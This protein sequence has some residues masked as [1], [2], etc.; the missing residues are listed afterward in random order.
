MAAG[1]LPVCDSVWI[2]AQA[3][4]KRSSWALKVVTGMSRHP[5]RRDWFGPGPW[6]WMA[7]KQPFWISTLQML[8]VFWS[9]AKVVQVGPV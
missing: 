4:L 7:L 1:A 2:R 8:D 3:F 6:L 9:T 5:V